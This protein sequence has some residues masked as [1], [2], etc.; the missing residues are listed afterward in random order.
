[1]NED[2]LV[3]LC[4]L[5]G[6][7]VSCA[8]QIEVHSSKTLAALK[9]L[10]MDENRASAMRNVAAED[11]I[12]W[13]GTVL[14]TDKG[15]AVTINNLSDKTELDNPRSPLSAW[16]LESPDTDTFIV[17]QRPHQGNVKLSFRFP[18]TRR[19]TTYFVS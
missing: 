17:V 12:L 8:F 3:L 2:H 19:P 9:D 11:L 7:P 18:W 1:M 10:I 15:S 4:L 13:R 5:E 16:F 6:A 14:G